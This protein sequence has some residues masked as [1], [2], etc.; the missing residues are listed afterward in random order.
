V[1]AAEQSV[2]V[3]YYATNQARSS[4][5]PGLT[6]SANGGF[7]NLLGSFI[8]NPGKWFVNLAGSLTAPLFARGQLISNLEATKAQQQQAMNNFE[9][10]LISAS[11]EVSEALLLY[12][13]SSEKAELLA[14][15]VENLKKAVEYTEDLLSLSGTTTYLEV[16]TAQQGLLSA[17]ISEITCQ[18][19]KAR[20]AINL[21]QSLG[22][23][24]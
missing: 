4:F 19:A 11:K 18:N 23:G 22:G 15:Q 1:R 9:Y 17:Q 20:A 24:R 2:A 6:I 14:Q 10:T 12:D 13:K 21:Y 7:T 5:Y 16:L 3:A 8:S